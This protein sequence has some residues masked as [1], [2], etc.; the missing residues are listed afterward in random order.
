MSVNIHCSKNLPS[1]IYSNEVIVPSVTK[2]A[3]NGVGFFVFFFFV[4]VAAACII[5]LLVYFLFVL[6]GFFF[7]L[8]DHCSYLSQ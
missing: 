1:Y 7:K 8:K 2:Y 6:F 3:F 4:V 5:F